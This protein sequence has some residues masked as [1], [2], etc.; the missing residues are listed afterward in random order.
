MKS[1]NRKTKSVNVH[2]I[3]LTK[4]SK[5][6]LKGFKTWDNY[7]VVWAIEEGNWHV[8]SETYEYA[9]IKAR[10][11]DNLADFYEIPKNVKIEIKSFKSDILSFEKGVYPEY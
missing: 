2:D 7:P 11:E 9:D 3:R 1:K 8:P 10:L 4:D 6:S 5:K